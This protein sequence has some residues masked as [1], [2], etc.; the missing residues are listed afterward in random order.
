MDLSVAM[1]LMDGLQW[2]SK[3][4][5]RHRGGPR[6][7]C[8]AELAPPY[9]LALAVRRPG[10]T[11]AGRVAPRAPGARARGRGSLGVGPGATGARSTLAR[12]R[13]SGRVARCLGG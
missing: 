7:Y 9:H 12:R 10:R 8:G 5:L 13:R 11:F 6:L 3:R 4:M 2:R 1:D